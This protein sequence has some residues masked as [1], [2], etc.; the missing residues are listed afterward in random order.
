MMDEYNNNPNVYIPDS[1]L[2]ARMNLEEFKQRPSGRLLAATGST[3]KSVAVNARENI[4]PQLTVGNVAIQAAARVHPL[5]AALIPQ[6][7]AFEDAIQKIK[8]MFGVQTEYMDQSLQQQVQQTT[9][10]QELKDLQTQ[11]DQQL[12]NLE[13]TLEAEPI[14]KDKEPIVV[15]SPDV[16][17]NIK[18][19]EDKIIIEKEKKE[20]QPEEVVLAEPVE[21][22]KD[23]KKEIVDKLDEMKTSLKN[24]EGFMTGASRFGFTGIINRMFNK[25]MMILDRHPALKALHYI[26]AT[27]AVLK[28][29]LT[30]P[31]K[32]SELLPS[33]IKSL[34]GIEKTP[35]QQLAELGAAQ[36]SIQQKILQALKGSKK[37][38]FGDEE[39]TDTIK[40]DKDD[41]I[42]RTVS[43]YV[44]PLEKQTEVLQDY[45]KQLVDNKI[46]ETSNIQETLKDIRNQT[47]E[48]SKE[49]INV[50][51]ET[52]KTVREKFEKENIKVTPVLESSKSFIELAKEKIKQIPLAK[53]EKITSKEIEE[54]K[55]NLSLKESIKNEI[56]E[57]KTA[58][59]IRGKAKALSKTTTGDI[60]LSGLSVV[61][62]LVPLATYLTA[63]EYK[64]AAK[65]T[66]Y[67]V[68]VLG[69]ALA[70]YEVYKTIKNQYETNE[71]FRNFIK[72]A[73][74]SFKGNEIDKRRFRAHL[75][76]GKYITKKSIRQGK[77]IFKEHVQSFKENKLS[78]EKIKLVIK[79][80]L[81]QQKQKTEKE[82]LDTYKDVVNESI[83][84]EIKRRNN[85]AGFLRL[86]SWKTIH[87]VLRNEKLTKQEN[88]PDDF[89]A[90]LKQLRENWIIDALMR[91]PPLKIAE[92]IAHLDWKKTFWGGVGMLAPPLY[93]TIEIPKYLTHQSVRKLKSSLGLPPSQKIEAKETKGLI[94][95]VKKTIEETK[96]KYKEI[97]EEKEERRKYEKAKQ[98]LQESY[99]GF[100]KSFIGDLLTRLPPVKLVEGLVTRKWGKAI[101]GGVG[102][103]VPPLYA[104][105]EIPKFIA[106]R[107]YRAAIGS[108][109]KK[110]RSNDTVQSAASAIG[111]TTALLSDLNKLQA[112]SLLVLL[113]GSRKIIDLPLNI[114]RNLPKVGSVAENIQKTIEEKT[115]SLE[116][117]L[118]TKAKQWER[119][120]EAIED[121][122]KD[123]T[124]TT[125]K[126]ELKPLIEKITEKLDKISAGLET[127]FSTLKKTLNKGFK[128]IRKTFKNLWKKLLDMKIFQTL[129]NTVKGAASSFW[130]L[131]ASGGSAV[132]GY[133]LGKKAIAGLAKKIPGLGKLLEKLANR[134][135]GTVAKEAIK[136]TAKKEATKIAG[137]GI[138]EETTKIATK[139]ILEKIKEKL[140]RKTVLKSGAKLFEKFGLK[141]LG[142]KIPLIGGAI[143]GVYALNKLTKGDIVGAGLEVLSGLTSMLPG[144]GTVASLSIDTLIAKREAELD[145]KAKESTKKLEELRKQSE[146]IQ[147]K[148][149][150]ALE[151]R[152]QELEKQLKDKYKD[153]EK[154]TD[155]FKQDLKDKQI[156]DLK[157]QIEQL[158]QEL[159]LQTNTNIQHINKQEI[160]TDV[161]REYEKKRNEV[162]VKNISEL[163]NI[164]NELN[165][166][167]GFNLIPKAYADQEYSDIELKRNIELAKYAKSDNKEYIQ[168]LQK[169]IEELQVKEQR[170]EKL[171]PPELQR[172][173]LPVKNVYGVD[174]NHPL[175]P[176]AYGIDWTKYRKTN[177][178]IQPVNQLLNQEDETKKYK[179]LQV[180]IQKNLKQTEHEYFK[181]E[182]KDK[183]MH[184]FPGVKYITGAL[185]HIPFIGRFFKFEDKDSD[186]LLSDIKKYRASLA[187]VKQLAYKAPLEEVRKIDTTGK[188]FTIPGKYLTPSLKTFTKDHKPIDLKVTVEDVKHKQRFLGVS[189]EKQIQAKEILDNLDQTF[190]KTIVPLVKTDRE[191]GN[192]LLKEYAKLITTGHIKKTKSEYITEQQVIEGDKVKRVLVFNSKAIRDYELLKKKLASAITSGRIDARTSDMFNQ[193]VQHTIRSLQIEIQNI[194][195]ELDQVYALEGYKRTSKQ[196]LL[197]NVQQAYQAQ[198]KHKKSIVDKVK[199]TILSIVPN[200]SV[201][202]E[203]VDAAE[204]PNIQD[205]LDTKRKEKI[206][207]VQKNAKPQQ[208]VGEKIQE[209]S[210]TFQETNAKVVQTV[211][212]SVNNSVNNMTANN[213][214]Q[215]SDID[216]YKSTSYWLIKP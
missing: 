136:S 27:Y 16:K 208:K 11:T 166:Q 32:I 90:S 191:L 207:D 216:Q 204:S 209:T 91:I 158:K 122:T 115:I 92:G 134:G 206:L 185:S 36:L 64:K 127:G 151:E 148:K 113:K 26:G 98:T 150:K 111:S 121:I 171:V 109:S 7:E 25:Y 205:V 83:Q 89:N 144:I 29:G 181:Q 103:L 203:K 142:K 188:E 177:T 112:Q 20:D 130:N 116:T 52:T 87:D 5:V 6:R 145:K 88:S 34:L 141:S 76:S 24:M 15:A 97:L 12:D 154:Q 38:D 57:V 50:L 124:G 41:V 69:Q 163:K 152:I 10:L 198:E 214:D 18:K 96:T 187:R 59:G 70:A 180:E 194:N 58:K 53:E 8:Q 62:P 147:D 72:S 104:S 42:E 85:E 178:D 176:N 160:N 133:L 9:L 71:R 94:D 67:F 68:P 184:A 173:Q 60:A 129:F 31:A 193:M 153:I 210:K 156:Q 118:K 22:P 192:K 117:S 21:L 125:L 212:N 4:E 143:A 126:E 77:Q 106:H 183:F 196:K 182:L 79:E 44:E 66:L 138:A 35:F 211:V 49:K 128:S 54:E 75:R 23:D 40:I 45:L 39:P 65:E 86:P 84:S 170:L 174:I 213:S 48:I 119:R 107:A 73:H 114:L 28:T 168:Q 110:V 201:N 55:K 56:R 61:N 17:V 14:K 19:D 199:N 33:A 202:P 93:A 162:N 108:I 43:K 46:N 189:P 37:V 169:Q 172:K 157:K 140:A 99:K 105:F 215:R 186:K 80:K 149:Y 2:Y 159:K 200:E 197:K 165:K 175:S 139:G 81:K 132:A 195:N 102:M 155:N 13:K 120:S 51:K 190:N 123:I 63:G 135:G 167:T 101:W 1:V 146:E 161:R 78:K 3:I 74:G 100:K 131:L 82:V 137:K 164:R 179:K 30:K 95:Q 47:K